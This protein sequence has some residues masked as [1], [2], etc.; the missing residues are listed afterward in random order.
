MILLGLAILVSP[1]AIATLIVGVIC[2]V[3]WVTRLVGKK[4]KKSP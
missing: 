2:L 4:V 3:A 1:I